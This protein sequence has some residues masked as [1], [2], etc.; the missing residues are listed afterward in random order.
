MNMHIGFDDLLSKGFEW[1][2]REQMR[3]YRPRDYILFMLRPI[4]P[5]LDFHLLNDVKA[6]QQML[7]VHVLSNL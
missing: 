7:F 1:L 3:Y 2:K 6:N 4:I 5:P